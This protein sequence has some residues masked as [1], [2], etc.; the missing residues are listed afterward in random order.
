MAM[1]IST[2]VA[3]NL[4][5]GQVKRARQG[6][7]YA[8]AI[9]LCTTAV[10]TSLAFLN[11]RQLLSVFTQDA[12]VL[13]SGMQFF[14]TIAPFYIVLAG[15]QILPGA[16]R[17]AGHVKFTTVASITCFVVLRQLYLGII[18]HI[19]GGAFYTITAVALGYPITWSICAASI[20]IYYIRCD[21][22]G[23]EK[24]LT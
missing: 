14:R 4:G 16:L 6:V 20:L 7:K 21:W 22:S 19:N 5:A 2:F 23:F 15:T 12:S 9:G 1:A 13:A 3:Q 24:R 11:T 10:L 18:T 8:I 17:G